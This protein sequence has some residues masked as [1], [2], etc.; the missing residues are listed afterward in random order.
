MGRTIHLFIFTNFLTYGNPGDF[1]KLVEFLYY[2]MCLPHLPENPSF[3][4][5]GGN[6]KKKRWK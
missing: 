2:F 6:S 5:R 3:S 4:K 1:R